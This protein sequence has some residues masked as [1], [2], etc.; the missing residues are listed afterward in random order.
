MQRLVAGKIVNGRLGTGQIN[1][2]HLQAVQTVCERERERWEGEGRELVRR[3]VVKTAGRVIADNAAGSLR[4]IDFPSL[5][6]NVNLADCLENGLNALARLHFPLEE[7][8]GGKEWEQ[9]ESD[10]N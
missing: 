2:F 3:K 9:N 6:H 7:E 1:L 5:T 8:E 4:Q 10:G